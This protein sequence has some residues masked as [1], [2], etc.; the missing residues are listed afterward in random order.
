LLEDDLD[1]VQLLIIQLQEALHVNFLAEVHL[2]ARGH[3][4]IVFLAGGE[5]ASVG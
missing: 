5:G 4:C 2:T 1:L 3:F